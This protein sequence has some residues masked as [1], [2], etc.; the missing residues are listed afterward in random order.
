MDERPGEIS[1]RGVVWEREKYEGDRLSGYGN[2]ND[3]DS[4]NS[5]ILERLGRATRG[6]AVVVV[7]LVDVMGFVLLTERC[8]RT[9]DENGDGWLFV[10]PRRIY[11]Y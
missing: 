10:G 9:V 1:S 4:S 5:G 8:A 7:L 6:I 11:T 3:R 2:W